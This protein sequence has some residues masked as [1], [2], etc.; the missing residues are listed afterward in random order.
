MAETEGSVL[1]GN[2]EG[3]V[4][5]WTDGLDD[6]KETIETKGWQSNADVLKSYVNLEKQVGADKVVLPS[7][8]T[9]LSEWEGWSK[10]GTPE[11]AEDYQ[12]SAPEGFEGYNQDLSDWF[13]EAAH[14]AKMPASQAQRL[15]DKF[16]EHHISQMEEAIKLQTEQSEKWTSELKKEY[17]TAFDERVSA[18]RKAIRTFGSDEL[19]QALNQSGLGDHPA[20]VRAFAKI[21]M[22][23]GTGPQMKDA[24]TSGAFGTTPEMAKE[25]IA[26]IRAHEG[27]LDPSHAEHKVLN[28]KLTRL[29][30]LAHGNEV[31][32]TA[33][34]G[35]P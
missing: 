33:G 6:Y 29:N 5:T 22:E 12:L 2:P 20:F 11:K 26:K 35:N 18:A 19:M 28:E 4:S 7:V 9:D 24:E 34:T 15:H 32:F 17:G 27:L 16:V 8:D 30:E 1:T 13:R 10:L 23:L 14:D 3:S 31:L 25:E 21:G